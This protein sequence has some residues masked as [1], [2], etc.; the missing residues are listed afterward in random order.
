MYRAH[1][2]SCEAWIPT[3]PPGL[4]HLLNTFGIS[5]A[6]DDTSAIESFIQSRE[7]IQKLGETV[8]L[9]EIIRKA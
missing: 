4:A 6:A 2:I 9:R 7:A 3:D 1:N 5:R 8:D